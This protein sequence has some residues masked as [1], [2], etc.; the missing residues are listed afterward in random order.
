MSLGLR[1]FIEKTLS[2]PLD[3]NTNTNDINIREF[4]NYN[5]I[6]QEKKEKKLYSKIKFLKYEKF[7][8]N[9]KRI[10]FYCNLKSYL[11]GR[12]SGAIIWDYL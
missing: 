3:I 5:T 7:K 4:K 10:R 11:K 8:N 1:H 6:L 9:T 2:N 12:I